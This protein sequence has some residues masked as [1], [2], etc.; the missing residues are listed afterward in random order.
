MFLSSRVNPVVWIALL[1]LA[2]FARAASAVTDPPQRVARISVIRG[3]VSFAPAGD[4]RWVEANLNRPLVTGDQLYTARD[5][6]V[7]LDIG[8][9][10]L[11]LDEH[12]RIS[13]RNFD[14]RTVQIELTEGTLNLQVRR[15]DDDQTYEVATPTVAL[16]VSEPGA[17]RIDVDARGDATRVTVLDGAGDVYGEADA[18]VRVD[19]RQS[20]RFN[21][22]KLRDYDVLDTPRPDDFDNWCLARDDRWRNS[23]TRRYVSDEVIGYSDLDEYGDW[24]GVPEY[25]HVWFPTRVADDWAPYRSGHWAWINPWGWTWVDNAPWGFAPSH[26]GRWVY[27]SNRWGWIPGPI[28]RRPVY[29]P[30]LVVFIGGHNWNSGIAGDDS[31]VGW[32]PLGPRDVY[33]PPYRVSRGYF[34][35]VNVSNTTVINN[36]H[37]TNI[38][39]NYASD[40]PLRDNNYAYRHDPHAVTAVPRDTFI[41]ARPVARGRMPIRREQL[42]RAENGNDI[43]AMPIAGSVVPETAKVHAA[44][45][46]DTIKHHVLVRTEPPSQ[47]A[48]SAERLRAF[49]RNDLRPQANDARRQYS[50]RQSSDVRHQEQVTGSPEVLVPQPLR[51]GPVVMPQY[52][53]KPRNP[54]VPEN[55]PAVMPNTERTPDLDSVPSIPR[56]S[57]PRSVSVS[58]DQR[59]DNPRYD[60]VRPP[61]MPEPA[62]HNSRNNERSPRHNDYGAREHSV[63][64]ANQANRSEAAVRGHMLSATG[65]DQA[66]PQSKASQEVQQAAPIV[67]TVHNEQPQRAQPMHQQKQRQDTRAAPGSSQTIPPNEEGGKQIELD[68]GSME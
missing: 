31:P 50:H 27:V 25:G 17:Y 39:N 40:R 41:H 42:E 35:N 10:A 66:A 51:M 38:Y 4:N 20:Y 65:D 2:L 63:E 21:D 23:V 56:E 68:S 67:P 32:C 12:S 29:A 53:G 52:A 47:P 60:S 19:K 18:H 62:P 57:L 55:E 33:V 14:D 48:P 45:S 24:D 61:V 49:E 6:R 46:S 5:A 34:T 15:L 7:E 9:A 30:A 44:P 59:P 3:D 8:A 28:A 37:I 1:V 22:A 26:Y 11:R 54:D 58:R 16:V 36:T 13:V 64:Q 43:V